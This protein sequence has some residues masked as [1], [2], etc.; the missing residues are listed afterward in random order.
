M[1]KQIIEGIKL[2]AKEKNISESIIFEAIEQ[3]LLTA[4]KKK[5]GDSEEARVEVDKDLG[6]FHVYG[7]RLVVEMVE[8]PDTEISLLEARDMDKKAEID[9][10][11]DVEITPDDFGRIALQTAKQVIMQRIREAERTSVYENYLERIDELV[12]ATV[13]DHDRRG[14]VFVTLGSVAAMLPKEQ[15]LKGEEYNLDDRIKVVITNVL[16]TT[17]GANVTVSRTSPTLVKRLF[18]NEVPEVYDGTIEIASVSREAGERSKIAV[19]THDLNVDPI[20]ACVGKNHSRINAVIR[21]LHGEKIDVVEW[22]EGETLINVANSLAP[23]LISSVI[24]E[25]EGTRE[26]RVVVPDDQLSLAIGKQG[27]NARLAARL[28][29]MKIDIKSETY[30]TENGLT[31][32]ENI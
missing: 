21:E 13:T 11:I 12:V 15:Q 23:A 9:Q 5:F 32:E 14:N 17:K 29:G 27:Q 25:D 24:M 8:F 26:A 7:K 3:A 1:S 10:E 20:G 22:I 16:K 30:M 4:Y 2:V 18:E 19:V 6:T 28:C 31:Y